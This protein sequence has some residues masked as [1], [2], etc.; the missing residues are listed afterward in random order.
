MILLAALAYAATGFVVVA[1]GEAVVVRRLGRTLPR[2]WTQGPH[3]GLPIG[4]DRRIRVRTDAVRR[5]EVGLGGVPGPED[6]PGAG[7]FLTGDRNVLRAR[8]VVQYRVADPVAFVLRAEGAERLL[9]RLAESALARAV[10]RR[11]VDEALRA[12]RAAIARD[13]EADLASAVGRDRLDLGVAIL[14]LSLTDARPPTEVEPAFAAAQAARSEHDRRLNEAATYAATARTLATAEAEARVAA[15]TAKADRNIVLARAR[16]DRFH[17][18]LDQAD[19]S[20][21]LTVRRLYYEA[22]RDLLP[23]V[24]RTILLT[25]DEPVDLS[26]LGAEP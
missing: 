13:A 24:R 18:L 1:P 25:P 12:G 8:G 5:L 6:E 26:I 23:R 15:A 17:I 9:G 2:A 4:L 21:P 14:G 16:A 3:L 11:G 22:L 20:R 7:E 10:A 19:R